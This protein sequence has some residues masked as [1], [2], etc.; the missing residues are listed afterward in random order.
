[1]NG[2]LPSILNYNLIYLRNSHGYNTR[3]SSQ[4]QVKLPKI[5]T[6]G[7]QSITFQSAHIRNYFVN[8]YPGKESHSRSNIFVKGSSHN[9][10]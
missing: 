4:H 8:K 9:I 6:Y 10:S 7:F 5:N 3:G 2:K 1:M